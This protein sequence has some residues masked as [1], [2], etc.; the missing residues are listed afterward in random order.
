MQES[1]D[2]CLVPAN[3]NQEN[4]RNALATRD[5]ARAGFVDA[6]ESGPAK[7]CGHGLVTGRVSDTVRNH[8]IRDK[9]ILRWKCI[10]QDCG[11]RM[12]ACDG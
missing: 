3:S 2:V 11:E 7:V 1:N 6:Q 5:D 9:Q 4:R 10:H 8:G 12:R